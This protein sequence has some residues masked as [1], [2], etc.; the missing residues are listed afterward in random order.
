MRTKIILRNLLILWIWIL[1]AFSITAY[2]KDLLKNCNVRFALIEKHSADLNWRKT[3]KLKKGTHYISVRYTFTINTI[4]K[5]WKYLKLTKN[6]TID[7]WTLNDKK[8]IPPLNGMQYKTISTIPVSFLKPGTNVL[9]GRKIK[10]YAETSKLINAS[11]FKSINVSL[12]PLRSTDVK[13]TIGP[14]ISSI[15]EDSFTLICTTNFPTT[16]KLTVGSQTLK[17][18]E[19]IF[20][21]F[22]VQSLKPNTI[23]QYILS[24][25]GLLYSGKV[26]TLPIKEPLKFIV[27]G[28][29]RTV[30]HQWQRIANAIQNTKPMFLI[31]VGDIVTNGRKYWQ[32]KEEFYQ[33]AQKLL[34][35]IPFLPTIG[36]HEAHA[37]ILPKLFPIFDTNNRWTKKIGKKLLIITI[38]TSIGDWLGKNSGSVNWLESV[39]SQNSDTEYIIV[40]NHYPAYSSGPHSVRNPDGTLREKPVLIARKIVLPILIKHKVQ[41]LIA[42]HDHFYE[43]SDY[44]GVTIIVTGGGGAPLYKI[45]QKFRKHINPYSKRYL[46]IHHYCEFELTDQKLYMQV[47]TPKGKTIDQYSWLPRR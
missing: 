24:A 32:W 4:D 3:L 26:R 21:K 30:T 41:L 1:L 28:D 9:V 43:R 42:G 2:A 19:Q 25:N 20:H 10:V 8:I 22:E 39:L 23:Y 29:S 18:P 47:K 31:H 5:E 40:I 34:R 38:D 36:N 6:P 44:K 14:I 12:T 37:P 33:P 35:N 15:S 27:V 16:L 46:P 7:D 45:P 17:S 11:N 13:F